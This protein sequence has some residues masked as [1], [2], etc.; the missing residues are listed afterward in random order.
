MEG[1]IINRTIKNYNDVLSSQK[2]ETNYIIATCYTELKREYAFQLFLLSSRRNEMLNYK[3]FMEA[4]KQTIYSQTGWKSD[5]M[6]SLTDEGPTSDTALEIHY[7]NTDRDASVISIRVGTAYADTRLESITS[8]ADSVIRTICEDDRFSVYGAGSK[9]VQKLQAGKRAFVIS[10]E[11]IY[12]ES[13]GTVHIYQ[14]VEI[15]QFVKI[16]NY[17]NR[18]VR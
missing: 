7:M 12:N 4:L 13:A 16:L 9:P 5:C 3:E 1:S 15:L 14:T 8:I 11:S 2:E 18:A 10:A 6:G 17:W